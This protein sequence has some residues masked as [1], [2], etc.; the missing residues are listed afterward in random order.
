MMKTYNTG[1]KVLSLWEAKNPGNLTVKASI[2][3]NPDLFYMILG[4]MIIGNNTFL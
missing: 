2:E 4:D 3:N 1:V